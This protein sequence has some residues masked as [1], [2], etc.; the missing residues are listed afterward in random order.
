MRGGGDDSGTAA[1]A[2]ARAERKLAR[3]AGSVSFVSGAD[4]K[5]LRVFEAPGTFLGTMARSLPASDARGRAAFRA[6]AKRA[7]D[8][9]ALGAELPQLGLSNKAVRGAAPEGWLGG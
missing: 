3:L 7:G 9:N 2:T 4:E 5:T 1:A 6:A 8:E